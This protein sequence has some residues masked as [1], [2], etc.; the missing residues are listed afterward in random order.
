MPTA[1]VPCLH[2][3]AEARALLRSGVDPRAYTSRLLQAP[4]L[5]AVGAGAIVVY[6]PQPQWR[7][8]AASA[9][10]AAAAAPATATPPSGAAGDPLPS[11]AMALE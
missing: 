2:L 11:D 5:P 4:A 6:R 3:A 7:D 9:A 8:A 10:A 1:D